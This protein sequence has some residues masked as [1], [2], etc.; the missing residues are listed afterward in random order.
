MM[1]ECNGA[2]AAKR[3]RKFVGPVFVEISGKDCAMLVRAIKS[4]LALDMLEADGNL[5]WGLYDHGDQLVVFY[6]Q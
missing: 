1:I 4:E 3:L 5:V 6:D 2:E